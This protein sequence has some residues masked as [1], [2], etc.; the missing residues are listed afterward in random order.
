MGH[1]KFAGH[2]TE[3]AFGV[4]ALLRV[5]VPETEQ[6]N[7]V[8]TK[9]YTKYIG[10]SSI[11]CLTPTTEEIARRAAQQI[12]RFNDPVPVDFPVTRQ[13]AAV[14]QSDGG[15]DDYDPLGDGPDDDDEEDDLR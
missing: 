5:D 12:E 11:Y 7:N 4:A 13:L 6:P 14:S 3:Q 9:P 1:K 2:V 8:T 10:V 15:V